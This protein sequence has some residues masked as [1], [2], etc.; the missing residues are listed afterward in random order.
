MYAYVWVRCDEEKEK[1]KKKKGEE[2]NTKRISHGTF[3]LFLLASFQGK[4]ATPARKVNITLSNVLGFV[5]N[6]EF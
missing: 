6:E 3:V 2:K 5:A 4:F 1:I